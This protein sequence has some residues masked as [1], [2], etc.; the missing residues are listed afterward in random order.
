ME[1]N[2]IPY[3][4]LHPTCKEQ[5]AKIPTLEEVVERIATEKRE[6]DERKEREKREK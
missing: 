4:G 3:I 1:K 2:L 5:L 6:E